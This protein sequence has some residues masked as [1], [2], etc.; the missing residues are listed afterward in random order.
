MPRCEYCG[1]LIQSGSQ[2]DV[3]AREW[4]LDVDFEQ[5]E[6]P[7]YVQCQNCDGRSWVWKDGEKVDCQV[8]DGFG[9]IRVDRELAADGGTIEDS[10]I[11]VADDGGE[12][13]DE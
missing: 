6:G 7:E 1:T 9:K 2:C 3:C 10:D 5:P 4:N 8:C 11:I 13:I 12:I